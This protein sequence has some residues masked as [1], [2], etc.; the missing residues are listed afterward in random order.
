MGLYN[1][2]A[3]FVPMI[4]SGNKTHTIR[5]ARNHTDKPGS[6]MHLYTGLRQ[7]NARLLMRVPCV[8]VE[9]ILIT[10]GGVIRINGV[11][12]DPWESE[13]LAKRDGFDSY[14]DM[15]DFWRTPK[16][17]LPFRGLIFHWRC[18]VRTK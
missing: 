7:K 18:T 4:L 15:I 2:K 6:T 11:Y 17:R 10:P 8:R 1:F 12:L 13:L 14:A 16:N 9:N 5:K 3:R